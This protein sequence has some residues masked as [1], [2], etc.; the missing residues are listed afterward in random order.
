MPVRD[1]ACA[2][3]YL[4]GTMPVQDNA[5]AGESPCGTKPVQEKAC[6]GQ[7][8]LRDKS[9]AGQSGCGTKPVRDK[10][11][12][13]QSL[14]G[15]KSVRDKVC[16]GQCRAVECLT[17]YL[18]SCSKAGVV[19]N[20]LGHLEPLQSILPKL[21]YSAFGLHGTEGIGRASKFLSKTY[22][23]IMTKKTHI[24]SKSDRHR[25][26]EACSAE[27]QWELTIF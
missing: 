10:A 15:T 22:L 9:R 18:G 21:A 27:S 8:S 24:Q 17:C 25:H 3:K 12:A 13:G 23:K 2:G 6:A 4:C 26:K 20:Q 1:N 19:A 16:A 11:C 5:C 7:C 14:F